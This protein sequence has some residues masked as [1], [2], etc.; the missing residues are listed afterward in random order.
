MPASVARCSFGAHR[1]RLLH[2]LS[3]PQSR[4]VSWNLLYAVRMTEWPGATAFSSTN[5]KSG[6][7]LVF[8]ECVAMFPTTD[9]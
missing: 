6:A 4:Q 9:A 5:P 3:V 1:E 8:N 7:Q 2:G